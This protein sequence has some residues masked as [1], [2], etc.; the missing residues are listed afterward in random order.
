MSTP[1]DAAL[2]TA[3]ADVNQELKLVEEQRALIAGYKAELDR[4]RDLVDVARLELD[5]RVAGLRAKTARLRDVLN[6]QAPPTTP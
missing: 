4:Y 6:Q 1:I 3:F 2:I 5:T